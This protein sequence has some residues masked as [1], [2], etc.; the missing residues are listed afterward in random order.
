MDKYFKV[1]M[2][3]ALEIVDASEGPELLAGYVVLRRWAMTKNYDRTAA[4]AQAI[5]K[6][7]GVTDFRAKRVLID[8]L[9]LRFGDRGELF[10][11]EPTGR[12]VKNAREYR[13]G[14]WEGLVSYLP[15]LLTQGDVQPLRRLCQV[16]AVPEVKRD[17]LLVLLHAYASVNYGDF[18]GV[19]PSEFIYKKW[20]V[21]GLCSANDTEFDL[22]HY[23]KV[24]GLHFWLVKEDDETR[25]TFQKSAD[26]IFGEGK[27]ALDRLWQA[28]A[29]LL[30]IGMLCPV[31]IVDYGTDTY[32]LWVFSPAYREA[33][34]RTGVTANLADIIYRKAGN[35]DLDPDNLIIRAATDYDTRGPEGTGLFFCVTP[36]DREPVV[37]TIYAPLFHAPNPANLD[38]LMEMNRKLA[39]WHARLGSRARSR[40]TA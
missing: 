1:P 37:R 30:Q 7:T 22:G 5:R 29:L 11:L 33:L 4:G 26:R 9:A 31:A 18:L 35:N 3:A 28:H 10:L 15:D 24:D 25:Y 34:E 17:A 36:T 8:L 2:K 32:P 14:A 39:D 20:K 19:D 27:N 23:G 21:D 6:A 16:D 38:G 40:R 13:F 12:Q